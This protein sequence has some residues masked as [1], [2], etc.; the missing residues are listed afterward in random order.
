MQMIPYKGANDSATA[1]IA[2]EVTATV[3][4]AGPVM[5][6]IAGGQAR[7]LAVAAP[8]KDGGIAGCAPP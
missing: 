6:Q 4:D 3:A 8:K 7:A 1:V 2:G 5:G